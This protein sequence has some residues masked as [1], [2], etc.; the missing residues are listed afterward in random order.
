[1]GDGYGCRYVGFDVNL[2]WVM[3]ERILLRRLFM[4]ILVD[5]L[6]PIF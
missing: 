5:L 6:L 1:M 2:G 4:L 3:A